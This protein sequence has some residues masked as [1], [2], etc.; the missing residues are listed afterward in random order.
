MEVATR[1]V[2]VL[3]VT[4]HPARAWTAQQARNLLMNIGDRIG[5]FRFLILSRSKIGSA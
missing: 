1:H 2:H 5:K 4:A 3:G